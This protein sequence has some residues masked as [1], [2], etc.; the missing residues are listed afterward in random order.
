MPDPVPNVPENERE[1]LKQFVRAVYD[2]VDSRFMEKVKIQDHSVKMERVDSGEYRL[3]YPDYD[4]EDF[5]SFLTTF[6]QIAMSERE[7]VYLPTIRNV[8]SR[9]GSQDLRDELKKFKQHVIPIIE[10]RLSGIRFGKQTVEGEVSF[11]GYQLL[12]ALVNG[13][14]FHAGEDHAKT[15]TVLRNCEPWQYIWV[16]LTEII[17]PVVNGSAWLVNVI[18]IEK[19][20]DEADF[21]E[22]K[23]RNA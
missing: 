9:Y 16:I 12:D 6:R 21:P 1:Q 11:S 7:P 17:I 2:M 19:L 13:F 4:W 8:V 5:R 15:V 3:T 20:L 22:R 18:R 10:G 23:E 14:V